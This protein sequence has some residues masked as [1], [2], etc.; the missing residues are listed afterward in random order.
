MDL[1]KINRFEFIGKSGR[2]I[3]I[4]APDRELLNVEIVLQDDGRT[5]KVFLG[6]GK[7]KGETNG[8]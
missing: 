4:K 6:H 2:E 3:V 1:T 7:T 8:R 5:L